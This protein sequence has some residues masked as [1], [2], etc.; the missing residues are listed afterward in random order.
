VDSKVGR[1]AY[2][3]AGLLVKDRIQQG[4]DFLATFKI[5]FFDFG[6]DGDL[7]SLFESIGMKVEVIKGPEIGPFL[8]NQKLEVD[9]L[10][11]IN[12][13]YHGQPK[14]AFQNLASYVNEGG[15]LLVFNS[16]P[17]LVSMIFPGKIQPAPHSICVS[18]KLKIS[19]SDKD[20]FAAYGDSED[21]SLEYGRYP[22]GVADTKN[23]KVLS[24]INAQASEPLLLKWTQ[25]SGI[26]YLWISR[27]F[28]KEKVFNQIYCCTRYK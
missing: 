19:A 3:L 10:V 25:G 8:V 14:E 16:A 26:A 2:S 15:R 6:S 11:I 21:I 5:R 20:I 1:I 22:V 28:L 27:M 18:A 17:H 23:V 13:M 24:K 4:K 9:Q 12:G 7:A